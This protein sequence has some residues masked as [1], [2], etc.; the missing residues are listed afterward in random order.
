MVTKAEYVA[1]VRVERMT[2]RTVPPTRRGSTITEERT[3][4]DKAEVLSFTVRAE[5]PH[6]IKN[7]VREMMT[8]GLLNEPVGEPIDTEDDEDEEDDR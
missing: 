7:M 4:R 8:A 2:P 6:Q 1:V 3:V 5:Q